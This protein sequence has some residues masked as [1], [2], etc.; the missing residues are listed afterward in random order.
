M[1][2]RHSTRA[3]DLD[4]RHQVMRV[5]LINPYELGRQPFGL[6][7]PAAWLRRAGY[8]VTCLDLSLERLDP[9]ALGEARLV[10]IYLGMHTATRIAVE[11][12]PRIRAL[13]PQ[14]Y[15]CAYGLYAPV[16]AAW[17]WDLGV[18]TLLGGEFE[19]A[20][21]ALAQQIE[22]GTARP[23][24]TPSI[25]RSK[26]TFIKPDRTGLPPLHRY[27]QLRMPNGDR[28]VV[29]FAEASRGC[30]HLCRHC[31]VVPVYE[32]RFRI[33]P[34]EVVLADIRD[35][36]NQ[37]AEH[38]S[39]GDPDFLN[40]PTHAFRI[41]KALHE[42]FPRVT[43]DATIKI[44]HLVDLGER[45]GLMRETGCLFIT[46]AVEAVDDTI[47]SH[48]RK[49]HTRRDFE[50]AV[51]LLQQLGIALAPTFVPFTPWT[52][53]EGYVELLRHLVAL[54]LVES[55]PPVQ[56]SIRLLVPEGSHLLQLPGFRELIDDFEP[57]LL[58]YP[59]RH[60]DPRLD[61]LQRQVQ[62]I[63][64]QSD[65]SGMMRRDVFARIWT[66]AHDALGR[67]APSLPANLGD[68]I[69][70][71]TEPWYCCAEPTEQQLQII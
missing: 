30:K 59:W 19:P 65:Q 16:N 36:V 64:A 67:R 9:Q 68:P 22:A 17:L 3:R 24:P 10:A 4:A 26:V 14:A 23:T 41:V 61:R 32:G 69:P 63:V 33:I 37:G 39:F 53:L 13:A 38:I 45:L 60:R 28:K 6:A 5:I 54:Q 62:T 71:L 48:L 50:A 42:E 49:G 25:D 40:G 44:E 2:A 1:T 11:A 52:T 55:V 47:L 43:F 56:L 29:G 31:P 18:H 27:A 12:L 46:S 51:S 7:Q 70:H 57:H 21:L 8:Q 66:L 34:A 15:L 58:G 35:Q 20:L